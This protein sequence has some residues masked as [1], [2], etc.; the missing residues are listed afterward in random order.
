[1]TTNRAPESTGRRVLRTLAVIATVLGLFV[2]VAVFVNAT[3]DVRSP[4]ER[5]TTP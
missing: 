2:A 4:Y 3:T 5:S 1:M